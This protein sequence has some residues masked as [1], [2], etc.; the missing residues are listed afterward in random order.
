MSGGGNDAA[1]NLWDRLSYYQ[2]DDSGEDLD[3]AAKPPTPC[4]LLHNQVSSSITFP[5]E[6]HANSYG[7]S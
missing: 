3:A 2:W 6:G 5:F 7:V 1:E 4:T